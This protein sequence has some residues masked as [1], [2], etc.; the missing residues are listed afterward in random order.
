MN[1]YKKKKKQIFFFYQGINQ[2]NSINIKLEWWLIVKYHEKKY[3][4]FLHQIKSTMFDLV[5]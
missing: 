4:P 1:N 5:E 2:S 3:L